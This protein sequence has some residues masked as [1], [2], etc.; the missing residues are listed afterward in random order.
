M[1]CITMANTTPT[2]HEDTMDAIDPTR[3]YHVVDTHTGKTV[4]RTTYAKRRTARRVQ[5]RRNQTYGAYRFICR[6]A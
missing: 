1:P 6:L 2:T 3:P 4:Y 5:E